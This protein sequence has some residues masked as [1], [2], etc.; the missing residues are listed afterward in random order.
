MPGGNRGTEPGECVL[1]TAQEEQFH[2]FILKTES[3]SPL[4]AWSSPHCS[5]TCTEG[6]SFSFVAGS[7]GG[8]SLTF[9]TVA[10]AS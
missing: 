1:L 3:P 6:F 8:K 10:C 2:L 7:A 4:Q 9:M 5:K